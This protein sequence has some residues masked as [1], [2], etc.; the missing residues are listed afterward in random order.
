MFHSSTDLYFHILLLMVPALIF[1]GCAISL[2]TKVGFAKL[3]T[4]KG[5]RYAQA[6]ESLNE[7]YMPPSVKWG[8]VAA[9]IKQPIIITEGELKSALA[10]KLG[11]PTA[12]LGGVWNF[13]ASSAERPLLKWFTEVKWKER[14]VYI[15][16]DSGRCLQPPGC[17]SR[18]YPGPRSYRT[19]RPRPY[20][21]P[22]GEQRRAKTRPRRLPP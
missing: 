9:D 12:G 5:L 6:P 7:V 8:K 20:R 4:G 2:N 17:R 16:Y 21:P 3:T 19:R 13:R 22:P 1:T 15:C 11:M 18:E 14:P 10:C